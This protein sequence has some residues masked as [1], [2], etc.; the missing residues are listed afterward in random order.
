MLGWFSTPSLGHRFLCTA[1]H[2]GSSTIS[3]YWGKN[4][5]LSYTIRLKAKFK[6]WR[7]TVPDDNQAL[8]ARQ[9]LP[10]CLWL[11]VPNN[12]QPY[13]TAVSVSDQWV[14]LIQHAVLLF[15]FLCGEFWFWIC[16]GTPPTGT[17][18][19]AT[20]QVKRKPVQETGGSWAAL[21]HPVQAVCRGQASP[22]KTRTEWWEHAYF[23]RTAIFMGL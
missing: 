11:L 16:D 17:D 23:G 20:E 14:V 2:G 1:R 15:F 21:R 3:L 4:E 22:R 13:R 10:S 6:W 9:S 19:V 18:A 7:W 8:I 12:L 5:Y